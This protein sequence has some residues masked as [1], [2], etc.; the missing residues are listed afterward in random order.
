METRWS[1]PPPSGC[2]QQAANEE[3]LMGSVVQSRSV[4]RR[5]LRLAVMAVILAPAAAWPT[6]VPAR[7]VVDRRDLKR[8]A[9]AGTPLTFQ[10]HTDSACTMPT[11]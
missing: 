4:M 2:G 10:L 7:Y 5:V 9:V 8:D 6:D 1:R 11:V 3:N